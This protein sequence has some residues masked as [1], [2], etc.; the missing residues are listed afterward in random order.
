MFFV[1]LWSSSPGKLSVVFPSLLGLL[2]HVA[3]ESASSSDKNATPAVLSRELG[4]AKACLEQLQGQFEGLT[5][6]LATVSGDVRTILGLLHSAFDANPN[7]SLKSIAHDTCVKLTANAQ[8]QQTTRSLPVRGTTPVGILKNKT[9][10][11]G[12]QRE[13]HLS[14]LSVDFARSPDC[15]QTAVEGSSRASNK[16]LSPSKLMSLASDDPESERSRQSS[17]HRSGR[18][19]FNATLTNVP[20]KLPQTD[21]VIFVEPQKDCAEF[22]GKIVSKRISQ[23]RDE[24]D[25]T[26]G[27]C[28]IRKDSGIGIEKESELESITVLLTT[29]L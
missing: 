16:K 2:T 14:L 26:S 25:E 13:A 11:E 8:K 10:S 17:T 4:Q 6:D 15:S 19:T 20:P 24:S 1:H 3:C 21:H 18:V 29:D 28:A 23:L 5:R 22:D 12:H 27:C 9:K 7:Y